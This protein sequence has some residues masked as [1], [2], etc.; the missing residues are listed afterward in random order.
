MIGPLAALD[1]LCS[2]GADLYFLFPA[3]LSLNMGGR[4]LATLGRVNDK[5]FSSSPHISR[6][7]YT[8]VSTGFI[9]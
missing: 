7:P 2:S 9:L 6:T 4:A 5:P 8:S 1:L 3:H